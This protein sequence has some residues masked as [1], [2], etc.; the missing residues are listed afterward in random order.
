MD[1]FLG[2]CNLRI[3]QLESVR[4]ADLYHGTSVSNLLEII[5]ENCIKSGGYSI[6][7]TRSIAVAKKFAAN[8]SEVAIEEWADINVDKLS[9]RPSNNE[10]AKIIPAAYIE[11][12]M[13]YN[14][15]AS[16]A[17]LVFDKNI[18][19][20]RYKI[21]PYNDDPYYNNGKWEMEERITKD[22]RPVKPLIKEIITMQSFDNIANILINGKS[23]INIA[24]QPQ[25]TAA[26]QFIKSRRKQ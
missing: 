1:I 23:S 19:K 20:Q 8:K 21:T 10:Y 9:D 12:Q 7:F 14:G 5:K 16:G 6:S 26:I 17:I 3:Y 15:V 18:L 22:I 25:Y 24:P 4:D 11:Q 2:I 13:V